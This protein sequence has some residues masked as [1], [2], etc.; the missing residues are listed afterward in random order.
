MSYTPAFQKVADRIKS[1]IDSK[2][3]D[4]EI[5]TYFREACLSLGQWER[6][7]NLYRIRPKRPIPGV[8]SRL[9]FFKMNKLQNLFWKDRTNRDLIVKMRQGGVTT[10][11]CLIG[12]DK[13]LWE[14]GT[15][16]AVMAHVKDNVKKFF[17]IT[18]TAFRA[19]QK[20]WGQFYPVTNTVDN[21]SELHI[22]ETGSELIV[23]TESKGLTLD[24][25]HIS[26]AAFVEDSRISESVESV[27]LSCWVIM[28]TTPDT[29][30][31][32]FYDLWDLYHKGDVSMY[33][34]HFFPW[35]TQYPEEE[36]LGM[37]KPTKEFKVT[38]KEH[39]LTKQYDL[40]NEHILWRRLKIS[41]SGGD[42]G[43]F[44]RKYPEDPLTCFLSGSSSEFPPDVLGALWKNEKAPSFIGDLVLN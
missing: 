32:M 12:L 36:D 39:G 26:E 23:C 21:V 42:E 1:L 10:L 29:A 38:D 6:L 3:S 41:E 37:L 31:G 34:G 30:A 14:P 44:L 8:P 15:H 19:F 28:E 17:R 43:E 33:K 13:A 7:N 16:S 35:W 22:K 11:S 5:Q 40:Q 4:E 25:L 24:F 20:D 18:K 9:Q 27:P 2:A